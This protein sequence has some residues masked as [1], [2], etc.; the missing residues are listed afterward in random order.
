MDRAGVV[1][2]DGPTHHGVFDLSFMSSLP[3]MIVSAP[4]DGN[5]LLDLLYTATLSKKPF[6]RTRVISV[7]NGS[8]HTISRQHY[9]VSPAKTPI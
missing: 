5:E 3:G 2:P 7:L 9:S 6:A 8:Y 1:G 4:K